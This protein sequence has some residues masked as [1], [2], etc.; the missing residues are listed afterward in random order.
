MDSTE[1][2]KATLFQLLRWYSL[3]SLGDILGTSHTRL[4]RAQK[5]ETVILKDILDEADRF[6]WPNPD[7]DEVFEFD[8][9]GTV[10]EYD[11]RVR[12]REQKAVRS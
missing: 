10:V 6:K 2:P 12:A 3:R 9:E 1:T 11:R 5:G 4:S 8:R 7:T